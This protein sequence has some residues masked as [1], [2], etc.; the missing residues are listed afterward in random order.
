M[1]CREGKYFVTC[2][3]VQTFKILTLPKPHSTITFQPLVTLPY[4]SLF[5]NSK[6]KA[7]LFFKKQAISL[8]LYLMPIVCMAQFDISANKAVINFPKNL[9]QNISKNTAIYDD[10]TQQLSSHDLFK[11]IKKGGGEF[12]QLSGFYFGKKFA[13]GGKRNY[14]LAAIIENGTGDTLPLSFR[15]GIL[16]TVFLFQKSSTN[17]SEYIFGKL[18]KQNK[19]NRTDN[20]DNLSINTVI[21]PF[22]VDTFLV[23][24]VNIY[25]LARRLDFE[26]SDPTK[27]LVKQQGYLIISLT[28]NLL[29]CGILMGF[30]I[31]SSIYYQLHREKA[32]L[33]YSGYLLAV[34]FYFYWK[35]EGTTTYSFPIFMA[36]PKWYF[37]FQVP[38]YLCVFIFYFLFVRA[39]LALKKRLPK[40]DRILRIAVNVFLFYM[41]FNFIVGYFDLRLSWVLFYIFRAIFMAFSILFITLL[42]IKE[43]DNKLSWYILIG[44]SFLAIPSIFMLMVSLK[45]EHQFGF[46]DVSTIPTQIGVVLEMCFFSAGLAYKSKLVAEE[47]E[48][49]ELEA[50]ENKNEFLNHCLNTHFIK[51]N[52]LTLIAY[53]AQLGSNENT[54][55]SIEEATDYLEEVL[56]LLRRDSISLKEELLFLEKHILLRGK[57]G[58]VSFVKKYDLEETFFFDTQVPPLLLQPFVENAIEHGGGEITISAFQKTDPKNGGTEIRCSISDK[59]PGMEGSLSKESGNGIRISL[60]RLGHFNK[61]YNQQMK[62]SAANR[63]SPENGFAVTLWISTQGRYVR[64]GTQ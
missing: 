47:K 36:N 2:K 7:Y 20:I 27:D 61:K 38:V 8:C 55:A 9:P 64:K 16:D 54:R 26:A 29:L 10:K 5:F 24:A 60:E 28:A 1:A 63:P 45:D 44:S 19:L 39:F 12:H 25:G 37:H 31:Q 56:A 35:M 34:I 23:K 46:W 53:H 58:R 32:Y 21:A 41:L 62:I 15:F 14:W 3:F 22:S 57:T 42:F 30:I 49:F 50:N 43:R 40:H 11:K 6:T 4:N 33:Y 52:I 51:N 13:S 48:K 18:V 59:G 17:N